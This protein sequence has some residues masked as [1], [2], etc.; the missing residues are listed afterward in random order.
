[1]GK[2]AEIR[3]LG[4]NF[5]KLLSCPKTEY[6]STLRWLLDMS[7]TSL[8][9]KCEIEGFSSFQSFLAHDL[10]YWGPFP[11]QVALMK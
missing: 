3:T 11:M 8:N 5:S 1:M 2:T 6:N 10:K 9:A 4:G 7:E